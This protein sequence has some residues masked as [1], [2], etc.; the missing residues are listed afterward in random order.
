MSDLALDP[1]TNDLLLERGRA[2]LVIGAD[3]VAQ[4]WPCHLTMFRGECFLD[5][6][7]G[8]D[9]QNEVLI[10]NPRPQVLRGIFTE[11][12][13]ETP[14]IA[15]AASIRFQLDRL[16]RELSVEVEAVFDDGTEQTLRAVESIGGS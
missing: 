6:S 2:R 11:A 7:L 16:R 1:A 14:G 10:K 15:S 5:R 8:I 12:T 4:S 13:L 9:Y 3:A